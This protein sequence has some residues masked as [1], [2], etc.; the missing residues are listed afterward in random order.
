MC[1][2]IEFTPNVCIINASAQEVNAKPKSPNNA[3]P[4]PSKPQWHKGKGIVE[5]K[6]KKK[7][8][9]NSNH[10]NMDLNEDEQDEDGKKSPHTAT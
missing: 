4:V 10:N 7:K 9:H 6:E 2:R 5:A 1:P 3:T 8:K